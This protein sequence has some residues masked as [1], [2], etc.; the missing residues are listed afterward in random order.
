M[1]ELWIFFM[2]IEKNEKT[3]RKIKWDRIEKPKSLLLFIESYLQKVFVVL[4]SQDIFIK[5]YNDC[6]SFYLKMY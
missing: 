1:E 4:K 3:E 5:R 6:R 2:E